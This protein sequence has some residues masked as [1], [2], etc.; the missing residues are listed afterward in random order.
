MRVEWTDPSTNK[1]LAGTVIDIPFPVSLSESN[2]LQSYAILFDNGTTASVPLN[3]MA[4][5]IPPPPVEVCNSD[6]QGSLLPPLLRLNSTTTYEHEGQY[7]KGYLGKCDGCFRFMFKSH[8]NKQKED[9]IIPLPNLPIS[10]MDLCIEG[11][12]LPGHVSH[13]FLCSLPSPQV[14]TFDPVAL[15]VS[16]LNLHRDCPS[17]FLK[18]LTDLHLD[19]EVWLKSYQEEKGGLQSLN[20]YF[21]NYS[22]GVLHAAQKGGSACSS[23][24]VPPHNKAREPAP[25]M[26]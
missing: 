13:S 12:L 17:T 21:K 5:L 24:H 11:I 3:E 2:L 7:H 22:W 8:V 23:Y 9:W 10:W 26:C 18:A 1:F 6:L 15:F 14:F 4:S 19:Q 16:T 25:A 20:T